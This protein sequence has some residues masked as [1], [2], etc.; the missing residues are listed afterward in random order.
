MSRAADPI[1][2][3]TGASSG[4]G[5][6][7]ALEHS[8]R[9]SPVALAARRIDRLQSI[10]STIEEAGG[11]A[12]ALECD[13]TQDDSLSTAASSIQDHY[14]RLDIVYANAGFG[15]GGPL[16]RLELDDYRRQ[17]ET[18]VFG[19]LRTVIAT[20]EML[21]ASRGRLAIIGS[22]LS[23][24]ALPGN[25]AYCMSKFAV[26][27]LAGSLWHELGQRGVSVTLV[28][29]GFVESEIRKVDNQGQLRPEWK[30]KVPGWL[31]A[32][33]DR[34]A[35][36]IIRAVRRRRREVIITGHARVA[37]QLERH[38]PWLV[39]TLLRWQRPG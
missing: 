16:E 12:I 30:D 39:H 37:V 9:G 23:W 15:V 32:D 10:C 31:R 33:A 21:E 18:N 20:R 29:P 38:L 27:A 8:R 19:A 2:L 26:R 24:I 28:A 3:I 7:L 5:R 4:I 25:S 36:I 35:R 6:A 13:V 22:A 17:L 1:V 14:G 34:V 11:S